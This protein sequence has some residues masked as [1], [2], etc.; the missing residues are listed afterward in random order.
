MNI[1]IPVQIE[2][3]G[4][5]SVDLILLDTAGNKDNVTKKTRNTL[6]EYTDTCTI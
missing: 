3:S 2:A 5:V 1:S 4:L 6:R